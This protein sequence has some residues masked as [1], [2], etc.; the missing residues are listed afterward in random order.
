MS[1]CH[2]VYR[3]PKDQGAEMEH[4][5]KKEDLDEYLKCLAVKK[6]CSVA[7]VDRPWRKMWSFNDRWSTCFLGKPHI[8][9]HIFGTTYLA[10]HIWH[11][12]GT[13]YLALTIERTF[14]FTNRRNICIHHIGT[15]APHLNYDLDLSI[16]YELDLD[17][18]LVCTH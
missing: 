9:H 11:H 1:S 14:L 5:V 17:L 4:K 15:T 13:T 8:W 10:P 6:G 2:L 18:D 16:I 12:I 3:I 7:T